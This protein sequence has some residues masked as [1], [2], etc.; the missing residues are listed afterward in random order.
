[1]AEH[2]RIMIVRCNRCNQ[3]VFKYLKVGKGKLV[4]CLKERI[5][6]DFTVQKGPEVFCP[7]GNRVGR[8]EG[9]HIKIF[10][11]YRLD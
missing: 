5:R 1:M 11:S 3:K 7:C 8:D 4:R 9:D 10:G 2:T 6:E